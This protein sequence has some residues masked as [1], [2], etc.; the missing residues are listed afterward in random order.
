M[1]GKAGRSGRRPA[2]T[3][4]P[5]AEPP[6]SERRC[7]R[8]KKEKEPPQAEK[9]RKR[10]D[11]QENGGSSSTSEPEAGASSAMT[12]S[13]ASI[14]SDIAEEVLGIW[15][16]ASIPTIRFDKIKERI[17]K[18]L[19]KWN[20]IRRLQESHAKCTAFSTSLDQLFDI[21]PA[22]VEERLNSS[23]NPNHAAP[24]EGG[25]DSVRR[26]MWYLVPEQVILCL[27]DDMVSD[28]EKKVADALVALP[29]PR[30][31]AP[32]KPN[33][34]PVIRLLTD[35]RPSLAVFVTER[36]WLLFKLFRLDT[37]WLLTEPATWPLSPAYQ[38]LRD[39]T[40]DMKVVNDSAERAV[41]DVQEYANMTRD[42]GHIDDVIL[43]GIDHRCRLSHLRKADLNDII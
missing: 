14:A 26:H 27:F 36:S 33:L 11:S 7:G 39:L 10:E 42:A 20:E 18:T 40:R 25:K 17:L 3:A 22:D 32:G 2:A 9:K 1:V 8:P 21:A 38:E 28:K 30:Y 5:A 16:R 29:A 13:N 4:L 15:E 12:R 24:G 31:F 19:T 43:V 41:K 6:H 35:T 37:A 23:S 34:Q